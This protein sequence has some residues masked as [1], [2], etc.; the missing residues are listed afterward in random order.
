M[1][2]DVQEFIIVKRKQ[3]IVGIQMAQLR[4]VVG[5]QGLPRQAKIGWRQLELDGRFELIVGKGDVKR[6]V[7]V[8]L[9][10]D[11]MGPKLLRDRIGKAPTIPR[12]S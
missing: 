6:C 9:A 2:D 7:V 1:L 10:V 11:P 4:L 12:R 5:L 8:D 3:V